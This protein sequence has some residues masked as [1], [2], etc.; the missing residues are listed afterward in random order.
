MSYRR[1][2]GDF[3]YYRVESTIQQTPIF[4]KPRPL[5]TNGYRVFQKLEF[6]VSFSYFKFLSGN[7]FVT[8]KAGI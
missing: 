4:D 8:E 1:G 5:N 6:K 7:S 2:M 3:E